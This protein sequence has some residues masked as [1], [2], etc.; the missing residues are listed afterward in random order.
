MSKRIEISIV[1]NKPLN[2]VWD[3]V[4]IMENHVN[5]MEDAV[6]IDILSENNSGLNTKMNVLTKV[7]PISLNDIITVT[8]WKE[9]ESIGVIHE[10]IVTGKGVFYLT[11]VDENTTKFKW[12]ETLKFPFYLGGPVGEVFGGLI[13]KLIW[14][15]NLKNLKEIIE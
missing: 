5:W 14:K 2:V 6:K 11:K 4:K 9:K 8:E 12:V 13:L 15:K 1:I 3:E 7:G 10:G